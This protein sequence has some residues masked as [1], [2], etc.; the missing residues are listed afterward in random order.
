MKIVTMKV[1]CVR[2]QDTKKLIAKLSDVFLQEYNERALY[3]NS[4]FFSNFVELQ[5]LK[6]KYQCKLEEF[7][8]KKLRQP[9]VEKCFK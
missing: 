4:R 5:S 7:F 6:I 1:N 3:K 9:K 8:S 2:K